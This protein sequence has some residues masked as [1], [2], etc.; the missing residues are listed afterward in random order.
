MNDAS[1]MLIGMTRTDITFF[2]QSGAQR[3]EIS[4]DGDFASILEQS[5]PPEKDGERAETPVRAAK[6]GGP[7]SRLLTL[8]KKDGDTDDENKLP[9][10]LAALMNIIPFPQTSAENDMAVYTASDMEVNNALAFTEPKVQ[11]ELTALFTRIA[12]EKESGVFLRILDKLFEQQNG[13]EPKISLFNPLS[14]DIGSEK[15]PD[16]LLKVL[17]SIIENLGGRSG[18]DISFVSLPEDFDFE[19]FSLASNP[20]SGQMAP[21]LP[22][23]RDFRARVSVF[24]ESSKPP[25]GQPEDISLPH[26]ANA[27]EPPR[28]ELFAPNDGA[29]LAG[30]GE[31]GPDGAMA[32]HLTALSGKTE[33]E[34][35]T[36]PLTAH[37]QPTA[38]RVDDAGFEPVIQRV[39]VA[40]VLE[41]IAESAALSQSEGVTRLEL[42]LNPEFLGKVSVV[43]TSTPDGLSATLKSASEATRNLLAENMAALQNTLRDMGV[44]MKSIDVVPPEINWDFSRNPNPGQGKYPEA[45]HSGLSSRNVRRAER[46]TSDAGITAAER[47]A[48]MSGSMYNSA[49]VYT[50]ETSIDYRA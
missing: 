30:D 10:E 1:A 31:S 29:P 24:I 13:Y 17:D 25:A 18:S 6:N 49:G 47:P 44:N 39:N 16:G 42:Q 3:S 7:L 46:I 14:E 50:D 32:R 41:Q 22:L 9:A 33:N 26:E 43:L 37:S 2:S 8:I 23:L 12:G 20:E 36:N 27:G 15:A 21:L 19:G 40:S 11:D 35:P 4:K 45:G 34:K 38:S 48:I 28:T 5:L